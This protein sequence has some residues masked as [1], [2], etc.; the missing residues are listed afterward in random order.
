M[1]SVPKVPKNSLQIAYLRMEQEPESIR[2]CT[3]PSAGA[4]LVYIL[5]TLGTSA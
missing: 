5:A 4:Y 1:P 3:T 2:D